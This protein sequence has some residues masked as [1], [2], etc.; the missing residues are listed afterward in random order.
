MSGY[1]GAL[2]GWLNDSW[3]ARSVLPFAW[4]A[5]WCVRYWVLSRHLEYADRMKGHPLR[6]NMTPIQAFF[7]IEYATAATTTLAESSAR[8]GSPINRQKNLMISVIVR[9]R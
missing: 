6:S 9:S 5:I 2:I 7:F 8:E 4:G 3:I 1:A